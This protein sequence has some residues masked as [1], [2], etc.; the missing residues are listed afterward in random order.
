MFNDIVMATCNIRQKYHSYKKKTRFE[1][2]AEK[3][4]R[5]PVSEFS[6]K[7]DKDIWGR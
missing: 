4:C 5:G 6:D 2:Q 1:L 7:Y 3:Q